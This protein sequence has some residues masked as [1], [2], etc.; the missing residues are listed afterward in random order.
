MRSVIAAI[1]GHI[2]AGARIM[3]PTFGCAGL[4]VMSRTPDL[5]AMT[6]VDGRINSLPFVTIGCLI[7]T[8]VMLLRWRQS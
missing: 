4:L 8:L 3:V 2:L 6:D 1:I 7:I 5:W